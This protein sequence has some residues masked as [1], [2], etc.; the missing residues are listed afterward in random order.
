MALNRSFEFQVNTNTSTALVTFLEDGVHRV[1]L[2]IGRVLGLPE[3]YRL[4]SAHS[5]TAFAS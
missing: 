4:P 5:P 3:S 2:L 1:Y